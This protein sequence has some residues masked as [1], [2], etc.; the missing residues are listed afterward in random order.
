MAS[1]E[2]SL[3]LNNK[4]EVQE[5]DEANLAALYLRTKRMISDVIRVQQAENLHKLLETSSTESQVQIG[6]NNFVDIR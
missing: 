1:T 6:V 4:F 5:E 3:T 2:I